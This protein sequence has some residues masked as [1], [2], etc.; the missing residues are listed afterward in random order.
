MKKTKKKKE[1]SFVCNTSQVL[2]ALSCF[3]ISMCAVHSIYSIRFFFLYIFGIKKDQIKAI[4]PNVNWICLCKYKYENVKEIVNELKFVVFFFFGFRF[5]GFE[6]ILWKW[7]LFLVIC[8]HFLFKA[9]HVNVWKNHI[10][11]FNGCFIFCELKWN[12]KKRE[13]LTNKPRTDMY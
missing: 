10:F 5:E 4:E 3:T 12:K 2:I 1:K 7:W 9:I 11:E 13:T 8:Y 6:N